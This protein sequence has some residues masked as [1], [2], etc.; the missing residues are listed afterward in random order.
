MVEIGLLTFAI[1]S[2]LMFTMTHYLYIKYKAMYHI[3][4]DKRLKY[5]VE[6]KD[7]VLEHTRVADELQQSNA[8]SR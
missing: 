5:E 7:L 4:L 3:E 6:V 8:Y 1:I 2:L